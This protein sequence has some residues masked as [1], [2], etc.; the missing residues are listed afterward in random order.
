MPLTRQRARPYRRGM[1]WFRDNRRRF[2]LVSALVLMLQTLAVTVATQANAAAATAEG[3]NLI[4]ICTAKGVQMIDL[5]APDKD[6]VPVSGHHEC[7]LCIVGCANCATPP[8][9]ALMV[10]IAIVYAPAEQRAPQLHVETAA[11]PSPP[12][13]LRTTTPRGPPALA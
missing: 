10:A 4:M 8:L 1:K 9:P 11:V 5:T 7:P 2:A 6:P 12:L 13:D 3:S